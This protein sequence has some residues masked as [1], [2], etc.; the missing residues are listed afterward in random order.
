[1]LLER[2]R[3]YGLGMNAHI[4]ECT[5]T[6]TLLWFGH[7]CSVKRML[8]E[9]E[10]NYGLGMDALATVCSW[11]RNGILIVGMDA[12]VIALRRR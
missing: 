12:L 11:N 8:L 4:I 10:R 2:E 1:M 7:E 5:R 6:G 3:Y 9:H